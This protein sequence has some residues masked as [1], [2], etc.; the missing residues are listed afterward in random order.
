M[1]RTEVIALVL[2][3]FAVSWAAPLIR[4]AEAPAVLVAALRLA[5]AAPPVA[6]AA[7]YWRHDELRTLTRG[8]VALLGAAGVALACHCLAW[9]AA[10][11]QTSVIASAVLVTTQPLL[12]ALAGW[13][14]LGERPSR[15]VALG[16]VI[17]AAGALLLAGDDLGDAG[18]LRG[19]ELALAG[20]GF[21]AAYF[22][23][24]RRLRRSL[25]NLAYVGVVYPIA[26]LALLVALAASGE[27]VR[28]HPSE[29]YA[30]IVLLALVPQLLGHTALNWALGSLTAVVVAI[31]VVGEPVG[32][33]LIAATL[34]DEPPTL[35]QTAGALGVLAGVFV[36]L[37][38]PS[39]EIRGERETVS[40][41]MER[42][43]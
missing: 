34:L 23:V 18:S 13:A 15:G 30:Y 6:L 27:P 25:S 37:W 29:A 8:E 42:H 7:L 28:G 20:A 3:V 21:A 2:G 31:A 26:A 24:G 4:L 5:I 11:Q 9:V 16:I 40:R 19:D 38:R 14:L 39:R 12:V 33:T 32:A 10:V 41:V 17:A 36:A 22:L 1:S 35:L 43:D